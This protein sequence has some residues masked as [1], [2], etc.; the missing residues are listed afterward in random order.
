ML[1]IVAGVISGE[2]VDSVLA[3]RRGPDR[4]HG[5]LWEFPGGKVEPGES[6]SVA[7]V[8]ELRE[9]LG[10]AVT[11]GPQL[12]RTVAEGPPRIDIRFFRCEA[13]GELRLTDHDAV[14]VVRPG[15]FSSLD[16]APGDV[17]FVLWLEEQA[18]SSAPFW[19]ASG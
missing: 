15:G 1:D 11:V 7:L 16:W 19:E 9:E 17:A 2:A 10:V 4:Q 12:F 13:A 5:G 8:R 18:R 14:E 3:F 6:D